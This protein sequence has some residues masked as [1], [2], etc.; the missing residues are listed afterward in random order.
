MDTRNYPPILSPVD[1][2]AR[3]EEAWNERDAR[4]LAAI[5]DEDAEFV[6][7][8]GIWWKPS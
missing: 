1:I 2:P 7:V 3:F 5:F 4:K 8:V 6:N